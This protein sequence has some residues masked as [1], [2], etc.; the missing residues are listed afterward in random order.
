MNGYGVSLSAPHRG[1]REMPIV[2][3]DPTIDDV[4]SMLD[5]DPA[6][7]DL[8]WRTVGP[9]L[10]VDGKYSAERQSLAWNGRNSGKPAFTAVDNHGYRQGWLLGK[11]FRAH[12]LCFAHYYGNFPHER[13]DFLNGDRTDLR[14]NNLRDVGQS[15]DG[16][17]SAMKKNNLSGFSGVTWD[18]SR[19][20][21]MAQIKVNGR[22]VFLG[23]WARNTD[24]AAAYESAKKQFGFTGRHGEALPAP[25]GRTEGGV[26]GEA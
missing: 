19:S 20:L 3:R 14:I 7:G 13:I 6:S 24:A 23:R 17:N 22:A 18:K 9:H 15:V 10:F 26:D 5:Y 8:R 1:S 21:W 25:P 2:Q 11:K 4:R 16:K 12:T